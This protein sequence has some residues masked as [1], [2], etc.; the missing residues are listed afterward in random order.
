MGNTFFGGAP[1]P[2]ILTGQCESQAI[3]REERAEFPHLK[4]W[5]KDRNVEL[6]ITTE[7]FITPCHRATRE[8]RLSSAALRTLRVY[9]CSAKVRLDAD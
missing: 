9:A 7:D 5:P 6:P 2:R 8:C 3:P 1:A 4:R